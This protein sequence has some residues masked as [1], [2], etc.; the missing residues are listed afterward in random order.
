MSRHLHT[1]HVRRSIDSADIGAAFPR[2]MRH[3]EAPIVRTAGVPLMLL[4]DRVRES[5]FK[6][7]LT[8]E[9]AD[10]VFGGYDIFKEGKIRRF[11]ARQPKSTWRPLLLRRLYGYL[12][13]SPTARGGMAGGLLRPVARPGERPVLRAS[14]PL[15]DDQPH[16]AH[17]LARLPGADRC[18]PPDRPPGRPRAAAGCRLAALVA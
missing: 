4:A 1:D 14:P 11:W 8:G 7:V 5:G 13:N 17:P 16:A 6:V 10:E 9:G 15:G 3:I 12:A 2:A 18:R